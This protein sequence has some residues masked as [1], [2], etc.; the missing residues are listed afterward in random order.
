MYVKIKP[1]ES[2]IIN[3]I[4]LTNPGERT[5]VVMVEPCSTLRVDDDTRGDGREKPLTSPTS[6][7]TLNG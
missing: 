3:G 4:R 1:R 7:A 6:P 2:K 5:M